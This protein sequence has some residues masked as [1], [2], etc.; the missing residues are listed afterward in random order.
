[1]DEDEAYPT[2]KIKLYPCEIC[3]R[4]FNQESL[5]KHRQIC[6]KTSKKE[7]KVFDSGRQRADGSDVIYS[8]TR[9]TKKVQVLGE[10]PDVSPPSSN[11]REKHEQFVR[12]VRNARHVT[13]A[14]RTGA[15]LPKFEASAVPS[16]YVNCPY[17]NRNFSKNAADRH[18]PF[19]ETQSKRQKIN[20]SANQKL[21]PKVQAPSSGQ[22]KQSSEAY[23]QSP[24]SNAAYNGARGVAGYQ[25]GLTNKGFNSGSNE[26]RPIKYDA[27]P[28]SYENDNQ[29]YAGG[30]GAGG[31]YAM[32]NK[33]AL[34]AKTKQEQM[35]RTGR[36]TTNSELNAL[37][38][39]RGGTSQKES[40][41]NSRDASNKRAPQQQQQQQPQAQ[42]Q[43]G[44]RGVSYGRGGGGQQQQYQQNGE[45]AGGNSSSKF[46][47]ECGSEFPVQWARFCSF[48]GDR[49]L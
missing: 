30:P 26:R 3:G 49:R 17:C 28:Y 46:C 48:C 9:E 42:N 23:E 19:C 12:T 15:P 25:S 16:D 2:T 47:H 24:N 7:R 22:R 13:E 18:I 11:W 5:V 35:L 33:A 32:R 39:N 34:A 1:M 14:I 31:S 44:S 29:D 8:K 41:I 6:K 10:K 4:N 21:K 37:A 43:N 40:P 20:T 45:V 36:N 38:R 27:N